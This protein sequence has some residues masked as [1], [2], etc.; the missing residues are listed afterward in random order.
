MGWM[1]CG[2]TLQSYFISDLVLCYYLRALAGRENN[3]EVECVTL[4][5]RI[6]AF[7]MPDYFI[8]AFLVKMWSLVSNSHWGLFYLQC[9]DSKCQ[10]QQ[11]ISCV[12]FTENPMDSE[13]PPVF[14]CETCRIERA[15]PYVF[16][17]YHFVQS[18]IY[19][20]EES[21][22]IS[23]SVIGI[24]IFSSSNAYLVSSNDACSCKWL[25]V[26]NGCFSL[27]LCIIRSWLFCILM[28]L[29]TFYI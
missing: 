23:L 1:N 29:W 22:L 14:Y 2:R 24:I 21:F 8:T 3:Y 28:W 16:Y 26:H 7:A 13:R 15:D 11:H 17:S 12:I 25:W 19:I 10:V 4:H 18:Y 9:I 6:G 5:L 27:Y 20:P